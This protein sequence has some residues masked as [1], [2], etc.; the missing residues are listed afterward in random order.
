[1]ALRKEDNERFDAFRQKAIA[2][3]DEDKVRAKR[4]AKVPGSF[5]K[6]DAP[7]GSGD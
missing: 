5:L 6:A 7:L 4:A 2:A 3:L 1:M